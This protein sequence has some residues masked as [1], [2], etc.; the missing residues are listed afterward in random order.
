M[1]Y[2]ESIREETNTRFEEEINFPKK[3]FVKLAENIVDKIIAIGTSKYKNV[4]NPL[5]GELISFFKIK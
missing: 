3:E 4:T 1:M 2:T 5:S